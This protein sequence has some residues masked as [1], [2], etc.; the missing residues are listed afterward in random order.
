MVIVEERW[1]RSHKKTGP[2]GRSCE[3]CEEFVFQACGSEL[4]H[5]LNNTT[6]DFVITGSL[7]LLGD[8]EDR[9]NN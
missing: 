4:E 7:D 1:L 3:I 6:K 2:V 8:V 5:G 9:R